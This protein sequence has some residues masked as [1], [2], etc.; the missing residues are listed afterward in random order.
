M[1][2]S[3]SKIIQ[4]NKDLCV[5]GI[6]IEKDDDKMSYANYIHRVKSRILTLVVKYVK[7]CLKDGSSLEDAISQA[8][9]LIHSYLYIPD[10]EESYTEEDLVRE[11][12][13]SDEFKIWKMDIYYNFQ[14]Y[15]PQKITD[16]TEI[17]TVEGGFHKD[18]SEDDIKTLET[19]DSLM[20]FLESLS[21][22]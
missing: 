6:T 14:E 12:C 4:S 11:I 8:D 10:S 21:P 13:K 18:I 19:D 15:H 20:F 1:L 5:G 2:Y 17:P 3:N 16:N 7:D 9:G 22:R